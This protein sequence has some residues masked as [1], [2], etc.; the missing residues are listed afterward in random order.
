MYIET[1]H[2]SNCFLHISRIL[3]GYAL[4]VS[5]STG[6][7]MDVNSQSDADNLFLKRAKQALE[8][9][10]TASVSFLASS[11]HLHTRLFQIIN[12]NIKQY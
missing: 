9:N 12:I 10:A 6:F 3:G 7:G 8:F 2:N 4:D 5:C 11:K 1:C